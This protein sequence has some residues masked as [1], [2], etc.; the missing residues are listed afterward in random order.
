MAPIRAWWEEESREMISR[1]FHNELQLMGQE[2]YTCEPFI[3]KAVVEKHLRWPSM[4]TVFPLQDLLAMD[5]QLR[6]EN[7]MEERINVPAIMPYY[8]R[9]R[10]HLNMETLLQATDFNALLHDLLHRSNRA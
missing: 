2:P 9:Y 6:R 3:A 8:W 5:L 1:Y 7:P 10:M 4:W